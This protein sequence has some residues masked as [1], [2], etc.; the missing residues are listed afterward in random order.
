MSVRLYR[1]V[2]YPESKIHALNRHL[3]HKIP[4]VSV[5][6]SAAVVNVNDEQVC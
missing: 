2:V 1:I 6:A 5:S 3:V 4:N